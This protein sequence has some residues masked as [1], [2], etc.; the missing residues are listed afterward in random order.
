MEQSPSWESNSHS[1]Q[2]IPCLL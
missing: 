2:E 1:A